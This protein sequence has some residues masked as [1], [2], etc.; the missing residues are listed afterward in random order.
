MSLFGKITS[1]F[2]ISLTLGSLVISDANAELTSS[3]YVS[4]FGDN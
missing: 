3:D 1:I 2:L 4:G